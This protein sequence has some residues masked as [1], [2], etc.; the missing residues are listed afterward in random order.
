MVKLYAAWNSD[1]CRKRATE[2]WNE[3]TRA[4]SYGA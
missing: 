2:R 4:E 3:A 1:E